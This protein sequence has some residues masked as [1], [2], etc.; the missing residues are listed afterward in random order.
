MEV[1]KFQ[2]R[3]DVLILSFRCEESAMRV[4]RENL[5]PVAF[6][7][8]W[9]G[10]S[11]YTLYAMRGLRALRVV[12]RT[13]SFTVTSSSPAVHHVASTSETDR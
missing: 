9:I 13:I 2:L 3:R 1:G 8:L 7:A 11:G 5:F 4:L 12:E 6:L 10:V